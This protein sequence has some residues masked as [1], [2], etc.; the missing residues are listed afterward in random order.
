MQ[1]LKRAPSVNAPDGARGSE[2]SAPDPKPPIPGAEPAAAD[3]APERSALALRVL[4]AIAVVG[5][6]WWGQVVLIPLVV[7]V[8]ITYALQPLVTR[9]EACRLP[10]AVAV[11]VLLTTLLVIGGGIGYGLRGEAAR[12]IDRL[13]AGA[14][15]VA[16]AIHGATRGTPGTLAKMR[17]AA[18]ELETAARAATKKSGPDGVTAVRIEEPT[19]KWSDW[20]WQG[21]HG[22]LELAGQ[23][24]AVL[25]LVYFLLIAGDLYKRKLVRMVPRLSN[26]RVTVEIFAEIDKQIERF[27]MARVVIS[28]VVGVVTWFTFRLLGLEEAGVWGVIA[29]VLYWIPIVGPTLVVIGA[30]LAAF[31]QFGTFEMTAIVAGL[32]IVIGTLEG[33]VLTPWLMSRVGEMNAVAVFVSLMFWGWL[34]GGWGLLLA[35]PITA[36][37]KVVA[38]RVPDYTAFAELLKE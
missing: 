7:S 28:L 37:A 26:K 31:I 32:C 8:V 3:A 27:L 5:G 20:V 35:V 4:A 21:S 22:A 25:C 38:E 15:V 16:A 14:H 23:I 17:Q 12:F 1:L 29:A 10:R 9:L 13:P 33:N 18:Y 34:W 24:I 11:P 2:E 19:F 6:L 36:A 30:A